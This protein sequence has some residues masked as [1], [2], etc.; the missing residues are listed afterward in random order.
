MIY[1]Q[2]YPHPSQR[3]LSQ[4]MTPRDI[5]YPPSE[6]GAFGRAPWGELI[7]EAPLYI[8]NMI[9]VHIS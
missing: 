9:Y 1:M 6:L 8:Q 7:P 2:I 4:A 3:C 5:I